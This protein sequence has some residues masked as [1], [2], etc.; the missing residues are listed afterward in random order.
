MLFRSRGL[1]EGKIVGILADQDGGARGVLAPFF[2][3][4]SS[5]A[6]G[7]IAL[8][9]ETGAPILPVFIVRREGPSHM[10]VVEEPLVIPQR[11]S[12][13]ERVQ[14]GIESYL[15]VLEKQIRR[16]PS[17]WLWFHRRWK[18]TPEKKILIFSD[19]K[20]GH[21]H[22]SQAMAEWIEKAW[23]IRCEK[24]RRLLRLPDKKPLCCVETVSVDFRNRFRRI[25]VMLIASLSARRFSGGDKWLQWGLTP[26]SYK[27]I[28][29]AYADISISC[30]A[31]TAPVHLLWAWAIRSKTI[32]ITRSRFPSWKRFDLAVIPRHDRVVASNGSHPLIVDGALVSDSSGRQSR[33][34]KK[35][36]SDHLGL[37]KEFQIGLFL[38]GPARGIRSSLSDVQ[39]VV[40]DLLTAAARLDAELLVTSSRRTPDLVE[41]WLENRLSRHPRCR[42]LALVNRRKFSPLEDPRQAVD[43]ILTVSSVV[44]VSGDS[45]SMVSEAAAQSP[46]VVSFLPR[47]KRFFPWE[48]KHR[49]FLRD[50][51]SK[52][53]ITFVTPEKVSEAVIDAARKNLNRSE[54]DHS[55]QKEKFLEELARWF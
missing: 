39:R 43:G 2:G 25:V 31:S 26:E 52:K 5:T 47:R 30:G 51:D 20:A 10:L 7:P 4:L 11:D 46:S 41:K 34:T 37:Q 3:R 12:F 19:G 49:R 9:L 48:T 23:K 17:Q 35:E 22:Q 44:I 27:A 18:S 16:A 40:D 28:R 55:S 36:W 32:H 14:A 1:Q 53:E 33:K 45:I 38:G 50:L 24:D 8:S 13:D 6:S 15:S 54:M 29:S 42:L 21:L